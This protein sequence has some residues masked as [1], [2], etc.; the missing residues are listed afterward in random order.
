MQRGALHFGQ[1]FVGQGRAFGGQAGITG[2]LKIGMGAQIAAQSG[3]NRDVPAG[4]RWGGSPAKPI[5][6]TWRAEAVLAKLAREGR[7]S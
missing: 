2:H 3:V 1:F 7:S 4:A 6:E 5:R